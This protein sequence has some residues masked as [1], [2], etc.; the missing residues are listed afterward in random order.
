[1]ID[2]EAFSNFSVCYRPTSLNAENKLAQEL[3]TLGF[4]VDK[5]RYFEKY[6]MSLLYFCGRDNSI[7]L[8]A[9]EEA[10]S[11]YMGAKI[12]LYNANNY[13]VDILK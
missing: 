6:P 4:K 13:L 3:K 12:I 9:P 5:K 1:M 7:G 8:Y 11:E 10:K 2:C